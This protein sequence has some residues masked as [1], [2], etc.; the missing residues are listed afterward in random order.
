MVEGKLYKSR[1]IIDGKGSKPRDIIVN[2][3]NEIVNKSPSKEELKCLKVLEQECY[4]GKR[5]TNGEL[6]N[7]LRK[8]HKENGRP[9]A[10]LDFNNNYI[11]PS[12][13]IYQKNFGSWN[14]ALK[15]AG[16]NVN[17]HRNTNEE[18]LNYN[19]IN[20]CEF[21]DVDNKRCTEMLYPQNARRFKINGKLV[22]FCERH[23]SIY[24]QK[25]PNSQHNII[26]SI[27]NCRTGNQNPNSSS[28]KGDK[29]Q[30][31]ACLEFGWI[32][33]NKDN[34]NYNSPIDCFDTMTG[35]F[36][37]VRGRLYNSIKRWWNFAPLEGEWIKKYEDMVCYCTNKD[38]KII[39]RIYIIHNYEINGRKSITIYVNHTDQ[40]YEQYRVKNEEEL[41]KANEI[42]KEINNIYI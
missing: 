12:F 10:Q 4:V 16:L 3:N 41:K 30:E 28:T 6:L 8:F 17:R 31:L 33:L 29:F 19:D 21:I 24:R 20:T 38:G 2:D 39:E 5:Y 9:P 34:D 35:L 40:W 14:N 13:G 22:W 42:W 1:R 25:L 23:S 15:L 18:S 11:Y 27:A 36:H 32:D 26:K 7:Y 37:Q